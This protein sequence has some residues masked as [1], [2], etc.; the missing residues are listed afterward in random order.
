K[1]VGQGRQE[2][3]GLVAILGV[4]E[5]QGE[6]EVEMLRDLAVLDD[7]NGETVIRPDRDREL[8][9]L[10]RRRRRYRCVRVLTE[11]EPPGGTTAAA[12][13]QQDEKDDEDLLHRGVTGRALCFRPAVYTRRR[14]ARSEP[15]EG[16]SWRSRR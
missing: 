5:D 4:V 10:R 6:A 13:Q 9:Q 16:E 2:Q 7:G 12:E 1:V 8:G 14:V 15:K 3:V 11:I